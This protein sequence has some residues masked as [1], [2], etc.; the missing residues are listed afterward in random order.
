VPLP[1]GICI[2]AL[3]AALGSL[4]DVIRDA[5]PAG[6]AAIYDQLGLKVT[7]KAGEAKI[8]AE[9]LPVGRVHV[10]SQDSVDVLLLG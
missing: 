6:K 4:L 1:E 7:F 9:V 5:G 8:R 10:G 2:R 3:I